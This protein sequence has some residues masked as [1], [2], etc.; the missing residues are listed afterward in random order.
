MLDTAVHGE[1]AGVTRGGHVRFPRRP[2][3]TL[4]VILILLTSAGCGGQ[5]GDGGPDSSGIIEIEGPVVIR[6]M[7]AAY[8]GQEDETAC[9]DLARPLRLPVDPIPTLLDTERENFD[10]LIDLDDLAL[11]GCMDEQTQ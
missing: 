5:P 9:E 11:F 1:K 8:E 4:C 10:E 3:L 2:R 7:C 6:S